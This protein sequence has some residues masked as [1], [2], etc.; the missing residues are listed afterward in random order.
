MQQAETA[1]RKAAQEAAT[2]SWMRVLEQQPHPA[3]VAAPGLP[4][5]VFGAWQF[6]GVSPV[7]HCQIRLLMMGR[8]CTL[9]RPRVCATPCSLA[10][11]GELPDAGEPSSNGHA[12]AEEAGRLPPEEAEESGSAHASPADASRDEA[13][14]SSRQDDANG[15]SA[16]GHSYAA[17]PEQVSGW[18]IG[19]PTFCRY[20]SRRMACTWAE[21]HAGS[22][23]SQDCPA[24]AAPSVHSHAMCM[25]A[26]SG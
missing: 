4:R 25:T 5:G 17:Q 18:N 21:W 2:G 8:C 12:A 10:G 24:E 6:A 11:A 7:G 23:P 26:W 20:M 3:A 15:Y 1:S 9:H 13:A 16:A 22:Q 14:L 19:N